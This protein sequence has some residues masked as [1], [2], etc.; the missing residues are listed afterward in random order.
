MT[1]DQNLDEILASIR[2][3]VAEEPPAPAARSPAEPP[4]AAEIDDA[5][6]DPDF[7]SEPLPELAAALPI[8]AAPA[9]A[10]EAAIDTAIDTAAR[11]L[12][13]PLLQAW[14]DAHLPE[15]VEA[16]VAA[17]IA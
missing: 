11:A 12:L 1:P 9:V 10:P 8:T 13:A 2:K 15:I 6:L 14:L 5:L 4:I 7:D 3:I 16:A 17:E